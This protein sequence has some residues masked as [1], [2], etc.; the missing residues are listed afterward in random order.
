[1]RGRTTVIGVEGD[2]RNPVVSREGFLGRAVKRGVAPQ[3]TTS[4][5]GNA[6]LALSANPGGACRSESCE[7]ALDAFALPTHVAAAACRLP[8]GHERSRS[9]AALPFS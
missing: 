2:C 5:D 1:M 4:P 7:N 9:A 8:R 3:D 6:P